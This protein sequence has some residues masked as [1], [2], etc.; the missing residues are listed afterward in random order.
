[1]ELTH[2]H[3]CLLFQNNSKQTSMDEVS[4][5]SELIKQKEELVQCI[6]N[7]LVEVRLQEAENAVIMTD[8]RTRIQ[9]L[10][11]E[12][13]KLRDNAVDNSVAHL[14]VQWIL[15][16]STLRYEKKLCNTLHVFGTLGGTNSSENER[17]GGLIVFER[18]K[19]AS[20]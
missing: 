14:Q 17:S 2:S 20:C 16:W 4:L 1:M 19:A 5:K 10:E 9:D 8:L 3:V 18:F 7:E 6:Q 13:K 12:K 11:E 15:E